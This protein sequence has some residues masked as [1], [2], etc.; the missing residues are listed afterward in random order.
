MSYTAIVRLLF[1]LTPMLPCAVLA[2]ALPTS[3]DASVTTRAELVIPA[4]PIA[5]RA[6]L[7]TYLHDTPATSS[8]LSWLTPGA[9]RRFL[10]SVVFG[11]RG[12][13]GM[14]LDD[15]SYELT[16]EQAYTLLRLFGAQNYAIALDA[17]STPRPA[18]DDKQASTLESPYDRLIAASEKDEDN[19]T[20]AQTLNRIYAEQFAPF[21]TDAQRRTLDDR[22]VEFLFRAATM[23]AFR[24]TSQPNYL[25]DMRSDF[26]ELARRHRVDR[27]HASNLYDMLITAHHAD[28]ARALLAAHPLIERSPAPIMRSSTRIR[29]GQPS[30]W[31]ATPGTRKRE[32]V[33]FRFN[34]RAP[35][36]VVVLASTG[37]HFSRNAARDIEADPMLRELF[38]DHAQ[39]VAP[40]DEITAFDAV[41]AW[42]QTHPALRLGIAYDNAALPM[43]ERFET[44]TFYFLSHGAVVDKVVGW[45]DE[46]NLEAI[47]RGLRRIDL[48]R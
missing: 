19:A 10:D 8:P 14:S 12:L 21:Q 15:L 20:Q 40:P 42:N 38:R 41:Q 39:W 34:I 31:I 33:R 32:L 26:A 43:V 9:Q 22:D 28:E 25:A 2:T 11:Q 45:P 1:A 3:P 7:D 36:Q 27:P 29:D 48:M 47:R 37:C 18:S 46:G 35:A 4:K 5:T 23:L 44:P 6:Q 16:R 13:G 17:R 30:L 24:V